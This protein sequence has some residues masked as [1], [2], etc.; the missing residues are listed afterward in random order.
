[1]EYVVKIGHGLKVDIYHLPENFEDLV[2]KDFAKFTSGTAKEFMF[3]DKLNYID[4]VVA[5][6]NDLEDP[7]SGV[8]ELL[9]DEFERVWSEDNDM[10]SF[11]D[12]S[13]KDFLET[14]Y[15]VGQQSQKLN[16]SYFRKKNSSKAHHVL[17][18]F[19][20]IQKFLVKVITIVM[21]YEGKQE[22]EEL[23]NYQYCDIEGWECNTWWIGRGQGIDHEDTPDNENTSF[24]IIFYVNDVKYSCCIHANSMDEALGIFYVNNP[25][26]TYD[27]IYE[28][29]EI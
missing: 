5:Q 3:S 14:C 8:T 19:D 10:I 11:E 24:E 13:N 12:I 9:V 20:E 26:I 1:M 25:H 6:I 2:K 27:M 16:L 18:D 17:D 22:F 23:K 4:M 15:K 7:E 21:N 29:V 28:H